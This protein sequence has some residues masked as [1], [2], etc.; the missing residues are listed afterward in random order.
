[1]RR[2]PFDRAAVLKAAMEPLSES[3]R[4]DFLGCCWGKHETAL[5]T[6]PTKNTPKKKPDLD[7]SNQ[8]VLKP[9]SP[10]CGQS[11]NRCQKASQKSFLGAVGRNMPEQA[12]PGAALL[13]GRP[14]KRCQKTSEPS[15]LCAVGRNMPERSFFP[16]TQQERRPK[17]I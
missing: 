15:T 5:S 17:E 12:L 6:K 14:R 11:R 2:F 9:G 10:F 1:M 3:K 8:S 13:R 16:K 4:K 7:Q